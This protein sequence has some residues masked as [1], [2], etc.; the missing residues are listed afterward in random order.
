MLGDG[1]YNGLFV[2]IFVFEEKIDMI[3]WG[4][5]RGIPG[6]SV[7]EVHGIGNGLEFESVAKGGVQR[8]EVQRGRQ[9]S[10]HQNISV[11]PDRR[12]EVAVHFHRK[13]VMFKFAR[14]KVVRAKV[15][16]FVH[17]P[18]CYYA[19]QLIEKRV[20]FFLYFVQ[21]FVQIQ[22]TRKVQFI[23]HLVKHFP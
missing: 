22:R 9:K 11:P 23:T 3:I 13:S 12:R 1:W 8:V 21:R 14:R 18:S 10:V 2:D 20:R 4:G 7:F 6:H 16:C 5:P 15:L 19:D 17:V